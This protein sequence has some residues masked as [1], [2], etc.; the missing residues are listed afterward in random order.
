M[1]QTLSPGRLHGTM[2]I[3]NGVKKVSFIRKLPSAISPTEFNCA[4]RNALKLRI[5][6]VTKVWAVQYGKHTIAI[7]NP[8]KSNVERLQN[9]YDAHRKRIA[10]PSQA[11]MCFRKLLRRFPRIDYLKGLRQQAL[12]QAALRARSN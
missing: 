3:L 10:V 11:N 2:G 7:N 9:K 12:E 8:I 5:A 6:V 4:S 1:S